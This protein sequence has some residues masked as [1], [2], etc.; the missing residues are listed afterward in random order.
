MLTAVT[1]L[2]H[3]VTAE[4]NDEMPS[5]EAPYPRDVGTEMMGRP[6]RPAMTEKSDA[7]IPAT[8]M[9]TLAFSISSTRERRR[10]TPATPTS[11]TSEDATPRYSS[12]ARASSATGV[13][14]VPAVTTATVPSMRRIGFP[15]E[16]WS[17]PERA[18]KRARPGSGATETSSQVSGVTR[19][20]ST[21]CARASCRQIS[22]IWVA[23]FP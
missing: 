16:R 10:S 3:E 17:V 19:V 14:E 4:S 11:G 18:S 6:I 2:A 12:V 7:S 8:A 15:T 5:S 9:T 22:T 1:P 21:S 20:T 13:S 23:V